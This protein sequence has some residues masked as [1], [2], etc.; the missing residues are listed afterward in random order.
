LIWASGSEDLRRDLV[1]AYKW[2]LLATENK[3]VWGSVATDLKAQLDDVLRLDQKLEAKKRA[4]A[5]KQAL[6]ALSEAPSPEAPRGPVEPAA[7][8]VC[9]GW[10]FPTLPCREKPPPFA[11]KR[12]E[13]GAGSTAPAP[14]P[15]V[16]SVTPPPAAPP[17]PA[18]LEQLTSAL[19]QIDCAAL[20]AQT[21]PQGGPVISGTVAD[22]AQRAKVMQ[23]AAR[24]FPGSRADVNL[25]IVPAP[26][27]RSLA[28][29]N[30]IR[31]TGLAGENGIAARLAGGRAELR[32]GDPIRVEVRGPA[33]PVSLRID[34][35]TLDGQV[36][37][38]WPNSQDLRVELGARETRVFGNGVNGKT[39]NAG[40][41]PFGTEMIAAIATPHPL[42]LGGPRR[43]VEPA[44]DYL[45][46]LERA[47]QRETALPGT[48]NSF[49]MVLVRTRGR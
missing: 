7:A 27:C 33:Y 1:E 4:D 49:A 18:P 34:Y 37:H 11:P 10:P 40:G 38:L 46:D 17:P 23:A 16:S 28:E 26:L 13:R 36:L 19:T 5:W 41:A 43:E 39:W 9:P 20:R 12:D 3:G 32:E 45:R 42:D 48:S 14:A 44:A 24:F 25:E 2:V 8:T 31:L 30:A 6:K 22:A 35:F 21:S 29:L 15:I 47:L